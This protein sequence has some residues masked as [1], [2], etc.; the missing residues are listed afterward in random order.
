[1][2]PAP[3]GV[4]R[5]REKGRTIP[6]IAKQEVKGLGGELYPPVPHFSPI[7]LGYS[8]FILNPFALPGLNPRLSLFQ[9]STPHSFIQ[10]IPISEHSLAQSQLSPA[11]T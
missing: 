6:L 3:G 7:S 2:N 11:P 5:K 10:F 8:L 9:E 4:T 1:M